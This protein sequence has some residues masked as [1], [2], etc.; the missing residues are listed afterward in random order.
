MAIDVAGGPKI[1]YELLSGPRR[2]AVLISALT[3]VLL[4]DYYALISSRHLLAELPLVSSWADVLSPLL[5]ISKLRVLSFITFYIFFWISELVWYFGDFAYFLRALFWCLRSACAIC[6]LRSACAISLTWLL[7]HRRTMFLWVVSPCPSYA[8]ISRPPWPG[9][10][11]R[12]V[13]VRDAGAS[14]RTHSK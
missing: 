7:Q 1:L 5:V 3:G 8:G 4:R 6:W 13:T 10:I 9:A 2:Y 14:L 11:L 12:T